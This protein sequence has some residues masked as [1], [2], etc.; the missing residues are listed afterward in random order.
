LPPANP[1]AASMVRCWRAARAS[2]V[3]L[4]PAIRRSATSGVA[5]AICGTGG[6]WDR[7]PEP[8]IR[9]LP[10]WRANSPTASPN[11]R[12]R[13]KLTTGGA[14]LLMKSGITG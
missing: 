6:L 9:R 1:V 13:R 10:S 4:R 14:T 2:A 7:P 5:V 3:G 8:M 11:W 12:A